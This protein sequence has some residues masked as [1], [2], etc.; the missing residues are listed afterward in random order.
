MSEKLTA[1]IKLHEGLRLKPYKCS[2]GK[3][4]IGYGRNL[5]D[6]GITPMEADYLLGHDIRKAITDVQHIFGAAFLETIGIPR[7]SVLV[8]M[9]FNLGVNRL[10]GFKKMIAAVKD[11]DFEKAADEMMDSKWAVQVGSRA[12]RLEG[13]MRTN[14]W[15]KSI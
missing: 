8:D 12:T 10:K 14:E 1:M 3:L 7:A 4:T 9:C 5:D 2:A 11:R 13:M 6:V 15:Y